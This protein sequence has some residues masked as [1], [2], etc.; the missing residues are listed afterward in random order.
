MIS[1]KRS[2]QILNKGKIK[3]KNE[4]VLSIN[5]LNRISASNIYAKFDYPS[6]D[7]A[8]F[9]GY[10]INSNDTK[11]LKKNE[12]KAFKIIGSI[13]AGKKPLNK[14]INKYEAIEI[15]TGGV[16]PKG[17]D[18]IIPIEQIIFYPDKKNPKFILI[19]KKI[20]KYNHVRFAGSDYKKKDLVIKRN[21]IILPNHI[22]AL[23]TLGIKNINVKKKINILFFSTG[24]EISNKELIPI[25]KVRNSNAHYI[26]NL[27]NSFLFNFKNGGI[28][29]DNHEN[30]FKAKIK[31]MMKSKI[32]ILITSGAVSAGKFDYIPSI[33]KTLNIS[34]YFKSVAIRPG[35]PILFA[36][37]RGKQKVIFGLPG[38][39]MSSSVCFRFFVYPYIANVLGLEVEKPIKAIL[40]NE[41]L[42]K[43]KFTRFVKSKLSATKDGKIEVQI[44]K[45]QES[46]RI[47][48]FVKSNI[49]ALL[50]AG[51]SKFK[52][53]EIIDCFFPNHPNQSLI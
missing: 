32:D 31:K 9:D 24:N 42:K 44:L 7:N 49:W 11:N 3:I 8:A 28:L 35:K 40:K 37:I 18:T 50:P 51:K 13:S 39:P 2:R 36:K 10:A 12:S 6:A 20:E 46:F 23:K 48:S 34:N 19:N 47:K 14:Q 33:V 41:F 17:F 43:K 16:I 26:Q 5:S 27:N 53:G 52:K 21:T 30:I 38:N 4:S 29:R 15:M 45:G 22:L 25:W 1:Y